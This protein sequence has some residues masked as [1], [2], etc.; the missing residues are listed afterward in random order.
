MSAR[1]WRDK[2]EKEAEGLRIGAGASF[3]VEKIPTVRLRYPVN[4]FQVEAIGSNYRFL[5]RT[6]RSLPF[7]VS[8]PVVLFIHRANALGMD[9][10]IP[11]YE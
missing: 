2:S 7:D 9:R 4:A 5:S 3:D 8:T 10:R 11:T 1:K 6:H